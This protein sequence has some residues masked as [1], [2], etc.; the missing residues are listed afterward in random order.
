MRTHSRV[1]LYTAYE[2]AIYLFITRTETPIIVITNNFHILRLILHG[3]IAF[4]S[5]HVQSAVQSNCESGIPNCCAK[6][7]RTIHMEIMSAVPNEGEYKKSFCHGKI[8]LLNLTIQW[9]SIPVLSSEREV[10][11]CVESLY[12]TFCQH[13]FHL[14]FF[15]LPLRSSLQFNNFS[16][17]SRIYR[18]FCFTEFYSIFPESCHISSPHSVYSIIWRCVILFYSFCRFSFHLDTNRAHSIG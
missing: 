9:D 18:I 15:F 2:C 10:K 1:Q 8:N 5:I 13:P 11:A 14:S 6:R 12:Y 16:Y 17:L 4:V 3:Y 7:A